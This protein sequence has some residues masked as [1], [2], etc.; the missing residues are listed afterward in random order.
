MENVHE[1]HRKRMYKKLEE[2]SYADHE[3][4]EVLLYS[5]IPRLNTNELAHRLISKCGSLEA[6]FEASMEELQKIEGVGV[7][8]AAFLVSIG[9]ILPKYARISEERFTEAFT[10][11]A[12]L[13]FVKKAYKDIYS[14]VVELYLLN[15]ERQ[16]IAKR[17]FSIESIYRVKVSPEEV[18]KFL[19]SH[20][21]SGVV[22]VHNHPYGQAEPSEKDGQ[23]TKNM[24]MLC[25]I[26]NRLLCDHFIYAPNGVYS[27]YLSGQMGNITKDYNI[28]RVLE[29]L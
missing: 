19:A 18:I 23:M 13:P 21:A 25:S 2:G 17:R 7:K 5:V 8:V 20:E 22:M 16:I 11:S 26:H 29:K 4:L 1:G 27:Y 9:K 3:W 28:Q 14:E 12:F 24:Q 10:S 15:G 6:V